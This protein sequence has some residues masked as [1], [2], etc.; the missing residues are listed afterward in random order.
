MIIRIMTEGQ[1]QLEGEAL[2]ELDRLDDSLFDAI[3]NSDGAQFADRF[4]EVLELVRRQSTR[5]P[6]TELVESELILPAPD[7]TMDEAR[8][9]FA[10]YPRNLV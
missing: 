1:Y 9:L 5:I 6:D 3:E 10:S 4:Q 7:T 2:S 8:E